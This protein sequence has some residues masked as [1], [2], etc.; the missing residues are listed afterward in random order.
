MLS[1]VC[2][3]TNDLAAAARFYDAVLTT[4]SMRCMLSEE[5]ERAYGGPDGRMTFFVVR[6][7]DGRT[8][9]HG[10][11]TQVMFYAADAAAVRA[12]HMTA[13]EMGG[14]DE[15]APGPRD[16]HPDYYGAYVRDPDGNK[17][18][19]SVSLET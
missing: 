8:A 14:T 10:N 17:L 16:Y 11:G 6:P 19:V 1:G 15:G 4:I 18:N 3:G 7:Y 5:N 9:T 2:V 12:F 13:L